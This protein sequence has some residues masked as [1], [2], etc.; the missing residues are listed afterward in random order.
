MGYILIDYLIFTFPLNILYTVDLM[1]LPWYIVV[2][3]YVYQI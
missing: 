2:T 1:G 3:K